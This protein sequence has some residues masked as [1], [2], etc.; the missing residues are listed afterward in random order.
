V[1][2]QRIVGELQQIAVVQAQ[3]AKRVAIVGA[4]RA[5]ATDTTR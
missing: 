2:H 4:S 3:H 1:L 5:Q